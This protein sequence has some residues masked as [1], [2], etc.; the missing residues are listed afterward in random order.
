MTDGSIQVNEQ[1]AYS[2][3]HQ[4]R[5]KCRCQRSCHDERAL[6]VAAVRFQ[7]P[8][9]AMKQVAIQHGN[10]V[11]AVLAGVTRGHRRTA[12]VHIASIQRR[13]P[14]SMFSGLTSRGSAVG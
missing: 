10:P 9:L 1:T 11:A 13:G 6:I 14:D 12:T 2:G 5:C 4:R 3:G 7:H 8:L